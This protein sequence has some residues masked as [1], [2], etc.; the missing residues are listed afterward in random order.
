[1][2]AALQGPCFALLPGLARRKTGLAF[3]V[4]NA[5]ATGDAG[6]ERGPRGRAV[7]RRVNG[8]ASLP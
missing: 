7:F 2:R 1:V 8:G 4:T 6:Y 5:V 3:A